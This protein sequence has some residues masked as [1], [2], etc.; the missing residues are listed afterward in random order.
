MLTSC[1]CFSSLKRWALKLSMLLVSNL[2]NLKYILPIKV[3]GENQAPPKFPLN[4]NLA[5][6]FSLAPIA[7]PVP[8]GAVRG[9]LTS[10]SHPNPSPTWRSV[11]DVTLF[12]F[13]VFTDGLHWLVEVERDS[14]R[15]ASSDCAAASSSSTPKQTFPL[16]TS[17]S[18]RWWKLMSLW[19]LPTKANRIR[20]A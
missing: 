8:L 1:A 9:L 11:G 20:V 5:P 13:V 18:S 19:H 7:S 15:G 14:R 4:P 12:R 10:P 6:P 2:H 17:G 3:V 16:L